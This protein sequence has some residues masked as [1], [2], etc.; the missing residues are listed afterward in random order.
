VYPTSK[1]RWDSLDIGKIEK[2]VKRFNT[3]Y[4]PIVDPSLVT[5]TQVQLMHGFLTVPAAIALERGTFRSACRF[6]RAARIPI[7]KRNVRQVKYPT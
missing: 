1:G 2:L 7:R 5:D 3:Y 6:P 4:V